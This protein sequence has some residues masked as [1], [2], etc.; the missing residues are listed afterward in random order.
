VAQSD[1]I[2]AMLQSG[3]YVVRK[4]AVDKLG[5][6]TMDMINNAD[7]LGYMG[8]GLVPQ[9]QHGHS[10]IDELLALNTLANQK[11]ID[12]TR[13]S[14]MMN[15]GGKVFKKIPEG[16]RGLMGLPEEVRNRMGYMKQG[17][18]MY[19]YMGGGMMDEYMYGGMADKKK[20]M[21]GYKKGG[22]ADTL[23]IEMRMANP[24]MYKGSSLGIEDK[25]AMAKN[26]VNQ[27]TSML[28]PT[29]VR[30]GNMVGREVRGMLDVLDEA[31][32]INPE[33]LAN[34]IMMLLRNRDAQRDSVKSY[35]AGG[36]AG[37]SQQSSTGGYG[38]ST[39]G[40]P[41]DRAFF[42]RLYDEFGEF[43]DDD[44]RKKFEERFRPDFS[45]TFSNIQQMNVG[46]SGQLGDAMEISRQTQSAS[47][48]SNVGAQP[49][50]PNIYR[51]QAEGASDI[52]QSSKEQ[53][54]A[55]ALAELLRLQT[56][57]GVKFTQT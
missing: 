40:L 52:F 19:D 34:D 17:G 26:R 29:E 2:P 18:M 35:F 11:S 53:E 33:Q 16:N 36:E 56:S 3:E 9:G 49:L 25:I 4:E 31:K 15:K 55:D 57:G 41:A 6:D 51:A 30:S 50:V 43:E 12:M 37:Q 23:Q 8:G 47:G 46:L 7:R 45:D 48:F 5:K 20:K 54:E 10:A 27:L 24:D 28:K 1:N 38:S 21:M 14:S 42:K 22:K 13:D 39:S 44:E 32:A